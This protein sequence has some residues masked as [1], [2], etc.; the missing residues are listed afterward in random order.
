MLD[1]VTVI[2]FHNGLHQKVQGG[3]VHEKVLGEMIR[4]KGS[5]ANTTWQDYCWRPARLFRHHLQKVRH[6]KIQGYIEYS[7]ILRLK[8][9]C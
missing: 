7:E 8:D 4:S 9:Y 6:K 3:I 2:G 5:Q 1:P